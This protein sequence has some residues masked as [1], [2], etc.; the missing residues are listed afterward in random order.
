MKAYQADND[1]KNKAKTSSP[2]TIP[3]DSDDTSW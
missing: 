1:Y 3:V 2:T